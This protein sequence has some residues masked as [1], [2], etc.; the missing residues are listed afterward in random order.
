[1]REKILE[2][3]ESILGSGGP[4][5]ISTRAIAKV[6]G[7]S[8]GALYKHFESL[9]EV[10]LELFKEKLP[11]FKALQELPLR[12]G[13]RTVE[14]NLADVL[15]TG[16]EFIRAA[17]PIWIALWSDEALRRAYYERLKGQGGGPHVAILAI[18]A[19]LE[20]EQRLGRVNPDANVSAS[21][22][23]VL[24]ATMQRGTMEK[25]FKHGWKPTVAMEPGTDRDWA[26]TTAAAV[27]GGLKPATASSR[28]A[29]AGAPRRQR[30]QAGPA[31]R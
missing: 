8:D 26:R 15:A 17:M 19:Y 16:L 4:A 30:G 22:S 20:A 23:L 6:A 21:A 9:D 25:A 29:R 10:L 31:K 18:S 14:E 28:P 3:A 11:T 2:A 24:A 1:M 5:E 13:K 7:C 12:V 27:V